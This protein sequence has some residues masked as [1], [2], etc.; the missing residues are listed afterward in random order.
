MTK[1]KIFFIL[2]TRPEVVKLAPVIRRFQSSQH[3]G[4]IVVNTG[5]H[6]ELAQ[7]FLSL[8]NISPSY[9]CRVMRPG[10]TLA[11]LS[12][13]IL[14]CLDELFDR[15][16]PCMTFVQGDTSSALCGALASFY[17][18]VPVA[19]VEAGL[20]TFDPSNPFPEETNRTLIARL[21]DEHFAPTDRACRH[22]LDE[23]IASE[24]ISVTGN[25]VVDALQHILK[26]C[27]QIRNKLIRDLLKS[28][29]SRNLVTI[30]AHRREN[31]EGGI[32]EISLA[33]RDLTWRF[34]DYRFVFTL[35]PNP[36]IREQVSSVLAGTP[37][38]FL[39]D[40]LA[41]SDFIKLLSVS[42]LAISDS[43]GLQ[44]EA[45]SLGVPV[46][47]TRNRTERPEI[48]EAGW[49]SLVGTDR[50][51]IVREASRILSRPDVDRRPL[52]LF[53]DGLAAERIFNR[54]VRR[55]GYQDHEAMIEPKELVTPPLFLPGQQPDQRTK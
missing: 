52:W 23:G 18:R 9:N 54:I 4:V 40:S 45:P 47:I 26:T 24:R 39:V 16:S 33:L 30:T 50:N 20:R 49:G 41:Y 14:H 11:H 36:L 42:R 25:T 19:H 51:V 1:D 7:S 15:E 29:G 21:T 53:G 2:G 32:R 44:E 12:A 48:L 37:G 35:H 43:G 27:G 5:Q 55:F 17:R 3:F 22:L 28:P 34:P 10:Q 46:L 38:I 13:R 31:W 8:F 6:R